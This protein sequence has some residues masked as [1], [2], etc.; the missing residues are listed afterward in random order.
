MTP[1]YADELRALVRSAA[2]TLRG[3]PEE[4]ASTPARAGAWSPK[5]IVG[6]LID[7]ASNN[8]GRFVRAQLQDHLRF[9]G[10]DQD[11]WVS[12]QRYADAPWSRLIDLWEAFN[13]HLARVME[14]VPDGI[15]LR[16]TPDHDLDVLAWEP[17]AAGAPATL[18]YF[19]RDYVGH[20]RHHLRQLDPDLCAAPVLQRGGSRKTR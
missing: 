10:Y 14:A 4:R 8:H 5:E 20:L 6:H 11:A 3:W 2:A 7:S 1:E 12:L 16:P 17:V 13:L 19:M 9:P 18:D 15:R